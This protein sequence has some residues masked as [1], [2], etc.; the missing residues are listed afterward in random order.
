MTVV[1]APTPHG[2]TVAT[3]AE[4]LAQQILDGER[5]AGRVDANTQRVGLIALVVAARTDSEGQR[6]L[7]LLLQS[8]MSEP[9]GEELPTVLMHALAMLLDEAKA[10]EDGT[11][12]QI[13][14]VHPR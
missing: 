4:A 7:G 10:I 13:V 11:T 6:F 3:L 5:A 2:L 1:N 8:I 12:N 14:E 9:F